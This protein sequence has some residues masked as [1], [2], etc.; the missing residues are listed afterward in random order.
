[1]AFQRT[2]MGYDPNATNRGDPGRA[3]GLL[4]YKGS[5]Q[6]L[7]V[8]EVQTAFAISGKTAQS[9]RTRSLFP[10]NFTQPFFTIMCQA[11]N[12]EIYGDTVEFIRDSQIDLGSSMRME[13]LPGFKQFPT[14]NLR[15]SHNPLSAEGYIKRVPRSHE[16]H[17]YVP[18]FSFEFVV[19]RMLSPSSW[20]DDK[21]MM[22]KL[23]SWNDVI[24]HAKSTFADDPDPAK[25]VLPDRTGTI[26][27]GRPT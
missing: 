20:S 12:Q 9:F 14:R 27:D 2:D 21:V 22:R 15:G 5:E 10:R 18:E 7:W 8:A 4:T 17:I 26:V 24:T 16:K 3:N 19:G 25:Y 6:K 1:M 13:V 23:L 11:P